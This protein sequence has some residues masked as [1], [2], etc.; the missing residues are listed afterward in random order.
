[1]SAPHIGC[2]LGW[3]A[4]AE[5]KLAVQEEGAMTAASDGIPQFTFPTGQGVVGVPMVLWPLH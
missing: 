3:C 5:V 1:M 4:A 2:L